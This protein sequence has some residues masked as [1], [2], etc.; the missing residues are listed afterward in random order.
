MK[1]ASTIVIGVAAA[2]LFA[3][4]ALANTITLYNAG[5]LNP[6]YLH[7]GPFIA[8]VVETVPDNLVGDPIPGGIQFMT[9]CL[10]INEYVTLYPDSSTAVYNYTIDPYAANGGI[11]GQTQPNRDYLDMRSA[12]LYYNFRMNPA[13]Y[14][15]QSLQIAFWYIENEYSL[16][17]RLATDYYNEANA[18]VNAGWTDNG[19]VVVLNLW[20]D[21]NKNSTYD[22]GEQRQSLIA[23][24][25]TVPEPTSL[26][27][28]GLGLVG[29]AVAG[30]KLKR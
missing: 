7:G 10:E 1:R 27:L 9:F 16:V 13:L 8:K 4:V 26:L 20:Y 24:R 14:N 2:F 22:S 15:T 5:P 23:L 21:K 25:Q 17:G 3:N 18:A 29:V 19:A 6:Q 12:Y 30:R 11:A 28:L